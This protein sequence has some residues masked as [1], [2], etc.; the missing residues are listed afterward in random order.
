MHHHTGFRLLM[1]VLAAALCASSCTVL[2]GPEYT[3]ELHY[4]CKADTGANTPENAGTETETEPP[5][6]ESPYNFALG[7]YELDENG[8]PTDFYTYPLPLSTTDEVMTVWTGTWSPEYLPEDGF[9]G[10]D[11]YQELK[12]KSGINFEWNIV[13]YANRVE[14]LAVLLASDALDDLSVGI[15]SYYSDSE[16]KIIDDGYLINI[17]DYFDYTP[18]YRRLVVEYDDIDLTARINGGLQGKSAFMP[19]IE[20]YPFPNMGVFIRGDWCR[21][22]GIDPNKVITYDDLYAA[23]TAFKTQLGKPTALPLYQ[24]V[25]P[26]SG[27][28]FAG[29]NTNLYVSSV[30]LPTPKVMPDGAIQFCLTTDDDRDA[31]ALLAQWYGEDLVDK[32]FSS[33]AYATDA[34][35]TNVYNSVFGI[36]YAS[37]SGIKDFQAQVEDPNCDFVALPRIRKSADQ[38]LKFGQKLARATFGSWGISAKCENIPLLLTFCDWTYSPE[39]SFFCSYGCEGTVWNYNE[40]GEIE[41]TDF[42]LNFEQ[43]AIFATCLYAMDR[44][45]DGGLHDQ[46]RDYCY[47]EGRELLKIT[48][49]W[50]EPDYKGEYDYPSSITFTDEQQTELASISAD[51]VTYLAENYIPFVTGDRGM[52]EWDSFISAIEDMG[53]G[54]CRKIYQDAYDNFISYYGGAEN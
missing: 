47:P 24:S 9:D 41:L 46:R 8:Y 38:K 19:L 32:N 15:A 18:N 11:Y 16:A 6:E 29:F 53:L 37:A 31:T 10:I 34:Y 2:A 30:G 20:A 27:W 42:V 33:F 43:G 35:M 26:G 25:E 44:L 17:C 48:E 21:S 12:E 40:N 49:F 23:L 1:A 36:F 51:L 5:E 4:T 52:S 7:K 45:S 54:D 28:L 39:G 3:E 22:V 50:T 14:N 13:A